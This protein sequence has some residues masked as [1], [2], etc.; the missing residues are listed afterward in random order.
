MSLVPKGSVSSRHPGLEFC[1]LPQVLQALPGGH[2]HGGCWGGDGWHPEP[3]P[4]H[5]T[6]DPQSIHAPV[7]LP[8]PRTSAMAPCPASRGMGRP[9]CHLPAPARRPV[10]S[11]RQSLSRG[12]L[13][14]GQGWSCMAKSGR[15]LGWRLLSSWQGPCPRGVVVSNQGGDSGSPEQQ[16]GPEGL[17]AHS[18]P[19]GWEP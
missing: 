5:L 3:P 10:A 1:K 14:P 9:G 11:P 15:E 13:G 17:L 19:G 4:S 8:P 7:S 6:P 18:P 16:E 2:C 12:G